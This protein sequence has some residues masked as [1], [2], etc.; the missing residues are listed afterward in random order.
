MPVQQIVA[1]QEHHVLAT[2]VFHAHVAGP[3]AGTRV[4]RQAHHPYPVRR[5]G[6]QPGGDL[7]S[8]IGAVVVDDDA[9]GGPQRLAENRPNRVA[10][11]RS[12][13]VHDDDDAHVRRERR[14]DYQGRSILSAGRDRGRGAWT[15]GTAPCDDGHDVA[16]TS[17]QP[18]GPAPTGAIASTRGTPASSRSCSLHR[19]SSVLSTLVGDSSC[20]LSTGFRGL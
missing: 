6:G 5:L 4:F 17:P 8:G 19:T 10:Q 2:R 11:P 14:R 1:V 3:P 18:Y 15:A 9:L 16:A 12:V 7:G 13:V 20:E